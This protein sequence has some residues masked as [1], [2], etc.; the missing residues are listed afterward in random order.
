MVKKSKSI[1]KVIAYKFRSLISRVKKD[2]C[3]SIA[4]GIFLIG[5]AIVFYFDF[6]PWILA[7]TGLHVIIERVCNYFVKRKKKG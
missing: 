4:N 5:L 6:W 2:T 7:L 1:Y 3:K